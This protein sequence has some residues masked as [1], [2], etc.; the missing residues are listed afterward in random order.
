MGALVGHAHEGG[1]DLL[2]RAT[3]GFAGLGAPW[4]AFAGAKVGG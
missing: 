2:R 1:V 4:D 3:D